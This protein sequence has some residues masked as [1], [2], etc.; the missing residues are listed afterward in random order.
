MGTRSCSIRF[1]SMLLQSSNAFVMT[2]QTRMRFYREVPLGLSL[3]RVTFPRNIPDLWKMLRAQFRREKKVLSQLQSV[4]LNALR[5]RQT[6]QVSTC[7][8]QVMWTTQE[9]GPDQRP[10]D[11]K[12]SLCSPAS[13]KSASLGVRRKRTQKV[14]TVRD[15][16]PP[17]A[18][19][20]RREA[21]TSAGISRVDINSRDPA[22]NKPASQQ[23]TVKTGKGNAESLLGCSAS[24]KAKLTTRVLLN[25]CV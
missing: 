3:V 19:R 15:L 21:G 6:V 1:R 13:Q 16:H 8:C 4:L 17:A 2:E 9:S 5:Q 23:K 24:R 14:A 22:Q 7:K 25:E 10:R 11:C 18:T 20:T 12:F